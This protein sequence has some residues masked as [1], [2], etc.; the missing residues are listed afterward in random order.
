LFLEEEWR[1]G[2]MFVREIKMKKKKRKRKRKKRKKKK[3][4]RVV[5]QKFF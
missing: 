5:P 2:E 3:K 4:Q 1:R